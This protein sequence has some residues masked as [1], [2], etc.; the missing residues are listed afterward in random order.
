[1]YLLSIYYVEGNFS[2]LSLKHINVFIAAGVK[3]NLQGLC[4]VLLC[5]EG[6]KG[7]V[8]SK[9]LGQGEGLVMIRLAGPSELIFLT[10]ERWA[11]VFCLS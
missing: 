1:M 2:G 5:V 11:Y 4:Q 3:K 6:I 8:M 10:P 9:A 7:E